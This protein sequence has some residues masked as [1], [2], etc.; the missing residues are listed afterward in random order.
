MFRDV[1]TNRM[2]VHG[3]RLDDYRYMSD[4]TN[5]S[6]MH[7]QSGTAWRVELCPLAAHSGPRSSSVCTISG[8]LTDIGPEWM[9]PR[10]STSR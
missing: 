4:A 2:K 10:N 6:R 1:D 5:N 7:K 9:S 8:V 3:V